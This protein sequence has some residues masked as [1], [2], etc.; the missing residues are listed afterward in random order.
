MPRSRKAPRAVALKP[1]RTRKPPGLFAN[2]KF[3]PVAREDVTDLALLPRRFDSFAAQCLIRFDHL[4]IRIGHALERIITKLED[5]EH[6][7]SSL[8]RAMPDVVRCQTSIDQRLTALEAR[9]P[10]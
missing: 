6:R 10:T 8:E 5:H 2:D 7:I 9:I 1:K 4:D 3:K